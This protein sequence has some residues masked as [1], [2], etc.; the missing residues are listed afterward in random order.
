MTTFR[1]MMQTGVTAALLLSGIAPGAHGLV[2][3]GLS[4]S[5]SVH[6]PLQ[7]TGQVLCAQCS[8][9]EIQHSQPDLRNL[10]QLTHARGQ[11][12]MQVHTVN[13]STMWDNLEPPFLA[14]RAKDSV[15]A[16]LMVEKNLTKDAE[17]TGILRTTR[18]LDLI[19]VTIH[20]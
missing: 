14:V 10:V 1:K 15:F 16:K 9:K 12:V 8:L 3:S 19:E 20:G 2:G 6:G 18:T 11:V 5:G 13:G 7:L 4:I 17:I